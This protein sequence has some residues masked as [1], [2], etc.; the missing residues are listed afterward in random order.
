MFVCVF[1]PLSLQS[2][3]F[4]PAIASPSSTPFFNVI[5]FTSPVVVQSGL[6]FQQYFVFIF[7]CI[8]MY[9]D[10]G[11]AH[12][13]TH[14]TTPFHIRIN[15]CGFSCALSQFLHYGIHFFVKRLFFQHESVRICATI[16]LFLLCRYFSFSFFFIS[17]FFVLCQRSIPFSV[18][19]LTLF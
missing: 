8:L 12:T 5:N 15:L 14:T 13:Y 9:W 7:F 6:D 1:F 17:S 3:G 4:F 16:V 18:L 2:F 11:Y 19:F 10:V